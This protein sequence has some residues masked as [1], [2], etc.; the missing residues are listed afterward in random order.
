MCTLFL[1]SDAHQ[2]K[3]VAELMF[4]GSQDGPGVEE[5]MALLLEKGLNLRIVPFMSWWQ[6]RLGVQ[7]SAQG[8]AVPLRILKPARDGFQMVQSCR[9]F[10]NDA[11]VFTP[12]LI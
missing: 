3:E 12:V 10:S 4:H 11:F 7:G 8:L 1:I 9:V 2:C 6:M 5:P